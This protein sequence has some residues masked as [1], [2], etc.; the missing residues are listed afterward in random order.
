MKFRE[1]LIIRRISGIKSQSQIVPGYFTPEIVTTKRIKKIIKLKRGKDRKD[2]PLY[3]C[4]V[5]AVF[6]RMGKYS[7][8]LRMAENFNFGYYFL[9]S[10][11]SDRL[12][13]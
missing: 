4:S 11:S 6:W 7:K 10:L 3:I 9:D 2:L 1:K 5:F 8:F 12:T 13:E